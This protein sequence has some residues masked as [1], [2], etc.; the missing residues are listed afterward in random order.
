MGA[1]WLANWWSVPP[2]MTVRPGA[3][4][5]PR[6]DVTSRLHPVGL[7]G[8]EQHGK[9]TTDREAGEANHM[10]AH[11][12][13]ELSF[14]RPHAARIYNHWLGGKDNFKIDR[15]V[16]DALAEQLPSIPIAAWA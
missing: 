2:R 12:S 10:S 9:E 11:E 13:V 15:D 14:D 8:N 4:P 3:V 1:P 7:P 6:P 16:G 5:R